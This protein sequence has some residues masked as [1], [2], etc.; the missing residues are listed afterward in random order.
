[1]NEE[2]LLDQSFWLAIAMK[3]PELLDDPEGTEHL[4]DRFTGQ[5]LQVLLR[6]GGNEN[7]DHV[8]LAFWHYLVAPRTRRKPFGLTGRTADLLITEFQSAL[9]RDNPEASR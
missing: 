3:L 8:W 5:Y 1:M 2:E 6:T 9:A 7:I 4:V